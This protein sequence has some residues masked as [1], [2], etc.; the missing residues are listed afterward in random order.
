MFRLY[1]DLCNTEISPQ[2]KNPMVKL[3]IEEMRYMGES[4]DGREFLSDY[5]CVTHRSYLCPYCVERLK[6]FMKLEVSTGYNFK[7]E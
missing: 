1:C 6:Q 2:D 3:T 4:S 5:K 7:G